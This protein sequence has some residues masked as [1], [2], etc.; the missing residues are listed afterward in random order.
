MYK[1]VIDNIDKQDLFIC[2]AA[3]ADYRP[4][5]ISVKKIKK[6]NNNLSVEL[7]RNKDILHD[8]CQLINKPICIGFAAETENCIKNAK[9]KLKNKNCDAIVLNDVSDRNIGLKSDQNEVY[10]ITHHDSQKIIKNSKTI[11]AEKI[12]KI[13]SK[14]FF[15]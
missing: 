15:N 1:A 14:K 6:T 2:C 8:V 13:I 11:I 7:V 10:F 3:I 9:H 12:I 4:S 5:K